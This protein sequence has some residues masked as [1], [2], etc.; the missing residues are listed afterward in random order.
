MPEEQRAALE[1]ALATLAPLL[2]LRTPHAADSAPE[3]ATPEVQPALAQ[4]HAL[5]QE[6]AQK[7]CERADALAQAARDSASQLVTAPAPAAAEKGEQGQPAAEGLQS[8]E[9]TATA[10]GQQAAEAAAAAAEPA[11]APAALKTLNGLHADGVQSV[12]ELCSLCLERLL[13]LARSLSSSYRYGKPANDVSSAG[14]W[15]DMHRH[16]LA[17]AWQQERIGFAAH[18]EACLAGHWPAGHRVAA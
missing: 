8:A 18:A 12:A 11:P 10:A 1:A 15:V 17:W 4:G 2:D 9:E 14:V 3:G 16:V 6:L 7:G 13:A 5:I